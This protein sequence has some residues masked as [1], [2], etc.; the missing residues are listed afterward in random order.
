MIVDINGNKYT[1][2][3]EDIDLEKLRNGLRQVLEDA[4]RDSFRSNALD[5]VPS[6]RLFELAY[7][8]GRVR[9]GCKRKP[10]TEEW[11]RYE[12]IVQ[13]FLGT[14]IDQLQRACDT[15]EDGRLR[16]DLGDINEQLAQAYYAGREDGA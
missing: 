14:A 15:C 11:R 1:S 9:E 12:S 16:L 13:D 7:T 3:E 4:V 2:A 10:S 5:L 6:V 8:L